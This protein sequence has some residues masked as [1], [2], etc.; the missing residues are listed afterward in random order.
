MNDPLILEI[1]RLRAELAEL[2]EDQQFLMRALLQPADKR[3]AVA[4]LPLIADVLGDRAFTAADVVAAALN[5]RTPD[6]QALLELVRE[7]ATD[8]GGLRAFGKMLARIEGMPLAG[9]RLIS[10]GDG[11][12][13]RRWRVV[14]LS[15]G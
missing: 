1:R 9:C 3:N 15:G 10:A 13:G 5:T 2:R 12:D 14:R 4:L 11:R 7:R 6:G 8:D